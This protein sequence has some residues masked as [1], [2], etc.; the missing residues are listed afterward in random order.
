M[1]LC[2]LFKDIVLDSVLV[3]VTLGSR[4]MVEVPRFVYALGGP[5][6][7]RTGVASGPVQARHYEKLMDLY[8]PDAVEYRY[9]WLA[10]RP[11]KDLCWKID[12]KGCDPQAVRL[13]NSEKGHL[14]H[15]GDILPGAVLRGLGLPPIMEL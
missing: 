15:R 12:L 9:V 2:E 14:I 7:S 11:Y 3:P 5:T 6:S 13:Y 1:L 8:G 4:A 10:T